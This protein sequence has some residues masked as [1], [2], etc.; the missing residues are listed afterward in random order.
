MSDLQDVSCELNSSFGEEI[1]FYSCIGV[2][3]NCTGEIWLELK[4][5]NWMKP[6]FK[7]EGWAIFSLEKLKIAH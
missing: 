7:I 1:S 6:N 2:G 5:I 4:Q 3:I